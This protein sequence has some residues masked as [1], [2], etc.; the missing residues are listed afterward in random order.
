MGLKLRSICGAVLGMV[1]MAAG[2]HTADGVFQQNPLGVPSTASAERIVANDNRAP[3]GTSANNLLTIDL[4]ARVGQWHP[5]GDGN[6]G[7]A[8]KAFSAGGGPLR[9][10]GPLIRVKQGTTVRASVR[11]ATGEPL[12]VHGLYSRPSSESDAA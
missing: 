7:V 2:V 12:V 4:E 9:V 6:S 5:D 10:P 1:L 8:V 3:A 11:N